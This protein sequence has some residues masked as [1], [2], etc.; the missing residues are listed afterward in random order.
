MTEYILMQKK[1]KYKMMKCKL[2]PRP[3]NSSNQK[4]KNVRL[5]N[6]SQQFRRKVIFIF[7]FIPSFITLSLNHSPIFST[8]ESP[9]TPSRKRN[10]KKKNRRT[11]RR[12]TRRW[13]FKISSHFTPTTLTDNYLTL[14]IHLQMPPKKRHL[15]S[16]SIM[17]PNSPKSDN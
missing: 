8:K 10:Q 1:Q 6:R 15:K 12:R 16:T 2:K 14:L 3:T 9:Y 13:Q 4:T 17:Q 5:K 7:S 11:T